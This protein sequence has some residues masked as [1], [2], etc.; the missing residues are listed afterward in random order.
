M[1]LWAIWDSG[2]GVSVGGAGVGLSVIWRVI[3]LDAV[4]RD[5][6]R[7]DLPPADFREEELRELVLPGDRSPAKGSNGSLRS[8]ESRVILTSCLLRRFDEPCPLTVRRTMHFGGA[9]GHFGGERGVLMSRRRRHLA[10]SQ[11]TRAIAATPREAVL[12]I[13]T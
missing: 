7:R 4:R 6:G 9:R 8:S 3:P 11:Q 12:P 13:V 10:T 2:G 1:R 5:E